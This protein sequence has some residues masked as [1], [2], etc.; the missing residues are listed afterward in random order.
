VPYCT[1]FIT[2]GP[3]ALNR[4]ALPKSG[5]GKLRSRVLVI[6]VDTRL[7]ATCAP[8][9]KPLGD[10]STMPPHPFM[11]STS[12]VVDPLVCGLKPSKKRGEER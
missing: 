2:A 1:A 9:G 3:C 10:E 6:P 4:E 7:K 8:L 12:I 11:A 5:Q